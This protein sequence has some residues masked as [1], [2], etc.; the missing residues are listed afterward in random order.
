[1][2]HYSD[3]TSGERL[4]LLLLLLLWFLVICSY[5]YIWNEWQLQNCLCM[6]QLIIATLPESEHGKPP[7]IV[8]D[9]NIELLFEIQEKVFYFQFFSLAVWNCFMLSGTFSITKY[10]S[11]SLFWQVDEIR[12][13]YSGL[14]VSLSDICLKPLGEDCATQSILQVQTPTI[15]KI[16]EEV[17]LNF[18]LHLIIW[19][20][21]C[22]W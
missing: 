16:S 17:L 14:L 21:L 19:L 5:K 9:D 12:A 20:L 4:W 3:T 22:V 6:F 10:F 11:I 18:S 15:K 1:M 7:S 8:T 2:I 13:N